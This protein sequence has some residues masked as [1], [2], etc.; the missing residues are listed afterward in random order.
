M[1]NTPC[2]DLIFCTG[3]IAYGETHCSPLAEQYQEAQAFFDELLKVCGQNG[4]TLE[5]NRLFV[6]PGNHDVNRNSINNEELLS[7]LG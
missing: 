2:P 7:G 4:K 1:K 3:D 6:V 5:K